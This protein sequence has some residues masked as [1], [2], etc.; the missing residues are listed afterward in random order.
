LSLAVDSKN[1]PALKLYHRHGLSRICTRLALIRD[2]RDRKTAA[3]VS[4]ELSH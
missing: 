1:A 2:L 4:T 3:P